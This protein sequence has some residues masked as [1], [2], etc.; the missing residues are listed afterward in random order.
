MIKSLMEHDRRDDLVRLA[1]ER[2]QASDS[3]AGLFAEVQQQERASQRLRDARNGSTLARLEHLQEENAKLKERRKA[4]QRKLGDANLASH[5]AAHASAGG[6]L[7]SERGLR[8][9]CALGVQRAS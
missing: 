8:H 1:A 5:R 9:V 6:A 2:D 4:N 7:R 3:A